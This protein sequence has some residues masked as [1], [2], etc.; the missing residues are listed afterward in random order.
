MKK[1]EFEMN[2]R[3]KNEFDKKYISKKHILRNNIITGVDEYGS[4]FCRKSISSGLYQ[5]KFKI[6]NINND[7]IIGIWKI[8]KNKTPPT[9]LHFTDG[10]YQGYGFD[11]C[12][13]KL[14]DPETGKSYNGKQ[15]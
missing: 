14:T 8:Q 2:W 6:G 5:Y 10:K 12:L 13:G 11:V 3:N 9:D 15:Y 1:E 7:M 4:S